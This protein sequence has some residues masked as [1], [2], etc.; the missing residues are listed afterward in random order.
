MEGLLPQA[1]DAHELP[2][3]HRPAAG[4]EGRCMLL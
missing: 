4:Q 3:C 1:A 2:A